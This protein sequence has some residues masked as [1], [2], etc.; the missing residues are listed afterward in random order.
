MTAT[1]ERTGISSI[2]IGNR[3]ENCLQPE[4][5]GTKEGEASQDV[6]GRAR[7]QSQALLARSEALGRKGEKK[8]GVIEGPQPLKMSNSY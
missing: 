3:L 5:V 7:A 6:L 1:K 2:H 8:K 4:I